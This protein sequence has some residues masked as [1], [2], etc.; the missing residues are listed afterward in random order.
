MVP[1]LIEAV[2]TSSDPDI[3][4]AV[5][6]LRSWDHQYNADCKGALLFEEWVKAFAG[7]NMS[8]QQNYAE[9]WDADNPIETPRGIKDPAVALTTLKT[10]VANTVKTLWRG[11]PALWRGLPL[12]SGRRQSA[13]QWRLRAIWASSAPSP[14]AR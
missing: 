8:N 11:G 6:V 1:D 9:K 2:G 5:G 12:P 3:Q 13:G 7:P 14:G 10:A 4:K